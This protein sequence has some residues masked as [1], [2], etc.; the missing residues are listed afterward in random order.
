MLTTHYEMP[1]SL[2][3]CEALTARY[4]AEACEGGVFME[5]FSS[6]Y[7]F[8]SGYLKDDDLIF[9]CDN[10]AESRKSACYLIVTSRILPAVHWNWKKAAA[11]CRT[12]EPNWIFMCFRS[13]GRDAISTN[14]YNQDEARRL[15]HFTGDYEGDCV[16]SVALHIVNEERSLKGA[17][18]FCRD[19]PEALRIPCWA[20]VGS[21][22]PLLLPNVPERER[23]CRRI[24]GNLREA[25]SCTSGQFTE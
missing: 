11:V 17:T 22:A 15:C 2:D 6:S 25:Y 14:A 13:Y 8:V 1:L 18:R 7:G 20:G 21:A 12:A 10:V 19:T 3:T 16:L 9:P 23:V 5:N 24:T 4:A